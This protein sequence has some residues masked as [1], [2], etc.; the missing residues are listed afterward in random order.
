[1]KKRIEL[2]NL[3]GKEVFLKGNKRGWRIVYPIRHP[4]TKKIIWKNL[5]IG[6]SWENLFKVGFIVA[7]LLAIK[8]SYKY[9]IEAVLNNC[10]A[11][12]AYG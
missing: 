8:Y 3:D 6:G 4:T 12:F 7:V 9:D 2:I 11:Y 5:L 10:G 1:M